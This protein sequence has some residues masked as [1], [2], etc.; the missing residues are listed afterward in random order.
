[1]LENIARDGTYRSQFETRVSNGGLTAFVGGD[2]HRWESRIFAGYYDQRPA[3][4]RPK[5]GALA[6][7]EPYGA[8]PRFGSCYF[9]LAASVL[10]RCSF[11]FP[12]S[13]YEPEDF[14]TAQR[15]GLVELLEA[16]PP[17][18]YLDR[19]VEAHVHGAVS[20]G[21]DVEALV[22]DPSYRGTQVERLA[23]QLG[24]AVEWHPGYQ[25]GLEVLRAHPEYRGA[26]IVQ[27]AERV[28]R[29][30]SL[31]PQ[32]LGEARADGG[33]DPQDLKRVWHCLARF[34]RAWS[35]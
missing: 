15:M 31:T 10:E 5:Y 13:Y 21:A 9:R 30:G 20:I 19:Y 27:V 23:N 1:M 34:G 4:E 3:A 24:C 6:H 33:Y 16:R 26:A 29:A 14:G 25:V 12:D 17:E 22:L 35:D 18:D 11:C 32:L 28:A 2:R 8:S 7:G